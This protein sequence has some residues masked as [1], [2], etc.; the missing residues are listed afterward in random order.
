MSAHLEKL[1]YAAAMGDKK[2]GGFR[3]TAGE[4]VKRTR[5]SPTSTVPQERLME[6]TAH[7]TNFDIVHA[8]APWKQ[9]ALSDAE[10]DVAVKAASELTTLLLEVNYGVLTR[11][12][13]RLATQTENSQNLKAF[14]DVVGLRPLACETT[15]PKYD[16][17]KPKN[18]HL[19]KGTSTEVSSKEDFFEEHFSKGLMRKAIIAASADAIRMLELGRLCE[20]L[21]A[22]F[23]EALVQNRSL[24]KEAVNQ[25]TE[26]SS[27]CEVLRIIIKPGR[28]FEGDIEDIKDAVESVAKLAKATKESSKFRVTVICALEDSPI[29]RNNL[30]Q[31]SKEAAPLLRALP[32]LEIFLRQTEECSEMTDDFKPESSE[33]AVK[34]FMAA[35]GTFSGLSND[36]PTIVC[37]MPVMQ[38]KVFQKLG[39]TVQCVLGGIE[40]CT[41]AEIDVGEQ[42]LSSFKSTIDALATALPQCE[43]IVEPRTMIQ[44]WIAMRHAGV[45]CARLRDAAGA[46][47]DCL[48]VDAE[49]VNALRHALDELKE[50]TS[51]IGNVNLA[52]SLGKLLSFI[53]C[54]NTKDDTVETLKCVIEAAKKI[55]THSADLG[56]DVG[57]VNRILRAGAAMVELEE[58]LSEM[59]KNGGIHDGELDAFDAVSALKDDGTIDRFL[60]ATAKGKAASE[61]MASCDE[62]EIWAKNVLRS[63][64]QCASEMKL[65]C[66]GIELASTKEPAQACIDTITDVE[67]PNGP[68]IKPGREP[69]KTWATLAKHAKTTVCMNEKLATLQGTLENLEAK[70][71]E[72]DTI[73]DR[74]GLKPETTFKD[75]IDKILNY[76]WVLVT[77]Q[78]LFKTLAKSLD[79]SDMRDEVA[80]TLKPMEDRELAREDV[81]HAVLN[82]RVEAAL[83][84]KKK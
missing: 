3:H 57:V 69:M 13:K 61:G 41:N 33:A 17:C 8:V 24:S 20:Q 66:S 19:D 18:R 12:G 11:L 83:R 7:F 27:I 76:G 54:F 50:D 36:L 30:A 6:L 38:D 26:I 68:W 25:I 14:V 82:A 79:K 49:D 84:G 52:G 46:I 40:Y 80:A 78:A 73:V 23:D 9:S 53:A 65:T 51:P 32:K 71:T 81:L 63:Q 59:S 75:Q 21:A 60:L 64:L 22:M 4:Y 39:K 29:L 34:V 77:T 47:A 48:I 43:A 74:Y 15:P 45:K 44:R 28:V 62:N 5:A 10:L 58:S 70:K 31:I 67:E 2:S 37:A 35:L 56:M 55:E 42:V 72:V 16:P 1:S